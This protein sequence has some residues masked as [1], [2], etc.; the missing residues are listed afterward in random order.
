MTSIRRVALVGAGLGGLSAAVA[1][2]QQGFEVDVFEQA[3]ELGEFGAGINISPNAVRVFEALGL[4]PQLHSASFQPT[5]IAWRDWTEGRLQRM[6]P[7]NTLEGRTLLRRS[8]GATCTAS[9]RRPP[10]RVY[11]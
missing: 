2:R 1:L 3:P 8:I 6:L 5:G 10:T 7:V 11:I 4:L 9:W